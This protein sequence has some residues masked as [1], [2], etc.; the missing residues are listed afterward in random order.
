LLPFVWY[1][2]LA[3]LAS[4]F[5]AGGAKAQAPD[6]IALLTPRFDVTGFIQAATREH[7]GVAP[8]TWPIVQKPLSK[9]GTLAVNGVT[10]MVPCNTIN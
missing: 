1:W 2:F 7:L 6:S 9:G 5:A 4:R 8:S 10:M 3:L